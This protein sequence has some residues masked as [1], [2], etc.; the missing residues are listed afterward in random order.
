MR[1]VVRE[2]GIAERD[3][4]AEKVQL[5]P[6]RLLAKDMVAIRDAPNPD[7]LWPPFLSRAGRK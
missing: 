5:A 4:L 6:L 2:C 3:S 1:C 7:E